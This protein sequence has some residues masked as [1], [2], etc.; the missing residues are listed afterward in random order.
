LILQSGGVVKAASR[1]FDDRK[2]A[3]SSVDQVKDEFAS[4]PFDFGPWVFWFWLDVNVTH[5]GIT[6]DLEAMKTAGIAGVIIMDVD[7]GTPPSFNGSRF[8]DPEWYELFQFACQEA[9]RLGMQVNMTNDAGWCGSAGPWI[10][11]E[12]SIQVVV[13]SNISVE[14]GGPASV[15]LPQPEARL[16]Y[17]RDITVLAFPTPTADKNGQGYRIQDLSGLTDGFNERTWHPGV[18]AELNIPTRLDWEGILEDQLVLKS[19]ILDVTEKMDQHGLLRCEMPKGNWTILRFGHTTTG[20]KNHP[21]PAGGVGLETDK[22]SQTATL[23]QF[24]ALMERIIKTIGPLAGKPL[25]ATHTL[26]VGKP[27][28]RTGR[29]RCGWTFNGC[30]VTTCCHTCRSLRGKSW[31]VSKY[32]SDFCGIFGRQLAICWWRIMQSPCVWRRANM[33]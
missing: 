32:P 25:V 19:R 16:N 30:A 29:Q 12:L 6:A 31:I 3:V 9:N 21:A 18:G 10:T 23:A 15:Q 33:V 17:Y 22:L 28:F 2:V 14:G 26:T 1:S 13:W 8:G 4:P 20:V 11:P 7:Q 27:V 24:D 5:E